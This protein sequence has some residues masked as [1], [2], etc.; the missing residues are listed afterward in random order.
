[1][2]ELKRKIKVDIPIHLK[3][4][5][6]DFNYKTWDIK[7]KEFNPTVTKGMCNINEN[8]KE[9]MKEIKSR[10]K[11]IIDMTQKKQKANYYHI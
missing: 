6:L 9:L 10:N 4:K 8:E 3:N 5:A 1:M 11:N 7:I 2:T